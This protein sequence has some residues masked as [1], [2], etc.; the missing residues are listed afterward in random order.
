MIKNIVF[1]IGNVLAG[2]TWREYYR[3]FGFSD[4]ITE[5]LSQATVLSPLWHEIDYGKMTTEAIIQGFKDRD[6]GITAEIEQVYAN[7]A[8]MVT[9]Y[10]YARPWITELKEQ[11]YKIYIISNISDKVLQDCH[12][13]LDFLPLVDG[14]VFSYREMLV[15][16]DGAIYQCFLKRYQ[17][18]PDE[19]IFLDDQEKNVITAQEQ[20]MAAILFENYEQARNELNR[21]LEK[22]NGTLI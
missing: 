3:S 10:D 20:G 2:F 9:R 11:G 19:C 21:Y 12:R 8:G 1:D 17:L 15:K 7:I 14:A 13:E 22:A 5:R 16:P 4:E 6:P 18:I